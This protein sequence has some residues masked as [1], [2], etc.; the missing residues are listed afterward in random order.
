MNKIE[1]IKKSC[2]ISCDILKDCFLNFNF[3]NEIEVAKY[4]RKKA[5]EKNLKLAFPPLVVSGNNFLEIHHNSNNTKLKGFVIVDFG[6]KYKDYCSDVAR[7]L[8]KGEPSRE[9]FKLFELVRNVHEKALKNLKIGKDYCDLD[10]QARVDFGNYK[11]YF[12][13]SL[14]HGV[15]KKIHQEPWINFKS[16]NVIK[17]NDII[18]IEPG[19]YSENF[20]IRIEDTILI[21]KNKIEVLSKLG[22]ELVIV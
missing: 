12:E 11:K 9:E 18:T 2:E 13:H 16:K 14:G 10:L 21:R 17:E 7:M 4:L 20:G 5:K 1:N 3:K 6:V 22:R 19:I 15:G 8:Y